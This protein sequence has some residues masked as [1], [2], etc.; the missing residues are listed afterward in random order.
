ML[1]ATPPG[2]RPSERHRYRTLLG[3]LRGADGL[4]EGLAF[5]GDKGHLQLEVQQAAR[6]EDW[7]L[8][9]HRALLP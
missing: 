4:P 8:A 7:R 3:D 2:R 9:V 1:P 5:E 6:A